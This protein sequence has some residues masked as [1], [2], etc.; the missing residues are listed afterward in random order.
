MTR[1]ISAGTVTALICFT[2]ATFG[3]ETSKPT[4]KPAA[5]AAGATSATAQPERKGRLP[6]H[7]GKLGLSEP[8]K[9]QIY[10]VQAKYE[11]QLEALERQMEALKEKRDGEIEMALNADQKNILARLRKDA[12]DKRAKSKTPANAPTTTSAPEKSSEK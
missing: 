10:A 1:L 6:P 11:D 3:Q 4:P 8:Q 5:G 2:L 12:D 9:T 7:F